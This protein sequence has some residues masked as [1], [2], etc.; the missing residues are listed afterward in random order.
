MQEYLRDAVFGFAVGDALGVPF[1]FQPRDSFECRGM[2]GGGTWSQPE[3]TWSDDT[4]MLLA[5]MASIHDAGRIDPDDMMH[6]YCNWYVDGEYSC[7]GD[8]F[9]IGMT[10]RNA[11]TR[12]IEGV[13]S[14][15][16]GA[17]DEHSN[18]NGSLMRI[19]PLAFT[20]ATDEDINTVSSL[21][22]AHEISKLCCR[23][24]VAIARQLIKDGTIQDEWI[25]RMEQEPRAKIR[26]TGY[27]VAS[28]GAAV[29][30]LVNTDSYAEAVLTAVNLGGDT[31]TIAALTGGL[32]GILYGIDEIPDQWL[33]KLRNQAELEAYL[34]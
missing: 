25:T 7:N 12:H 10:T 31:D 33:R 8:V 24:Y 1:E 17:S 15:L 21:T 16:C 23:Q 29:W 28:L 26:S 30:C 32:A 14:F 4:S 2:I 9:D 6:R 13:P 11:L 3:G 20:N 18:G 19:L 27:V 34:F 5:T 22:H